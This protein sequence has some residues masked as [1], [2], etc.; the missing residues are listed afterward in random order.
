MSPLLWSIVIF[1]GSLVL[2][3]TGI[4][5]MSAVSV[6]TVLAYV[7][8]GCLDTGK[9]LSGFADP[10]AMI[11]ASMYVL[12]AGFQRTRFMNTLSDWVVKVSKGSMKWAWLGYLLMAALLTSFVPSPISAFLVI[13]PLCIRTCRSF[14]EDPRKYLFP[15]AAVSI[16]CCFTLPFGSA[17]SQSYLS[18][19][20]FEAYGL[21]QYTMIPTDAIRGRWPATVLL[22]VWAYFSGLRA[23]TESAEG[24]DFSRFVPAQQEKP[25]SRLAEWMGPIIFFGT[26][27][28]MALGRYLGIETWQACMAGALAMVIFRVLTEKEAYRALPMSVIFL[29]VGAVATGN[30]LIQTGAG[31]L[32]GDFLAGLLGNTTNNYLVGALF[33]LIPYLL[34]Q[35]LLNSG[36]TAL[37]RPVL[38][39]VC[40]SLGANPVGPSILM[41]SASVSSFFSP[42]A[43]PV[44]P[45][46]MELGGYR[47]KTLVRRG[48]WI[49]ALLAAVQI[50]YVMT[51]FPAF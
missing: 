32:I 25:L 23:K 22:L 50:I 11:Y 38:L 8:T 10:T 47:T 36:V 4:M 2:Y 35:V 42:M 24:I 39:L 6:L 44:V 16:G 9:A 46:C 21:G 28:L 31:T 49:S 37:F 30:A 12:A 41:L 51:V 17:I 13:S 14:G 29:Y 33:Y 3:A 26:I 48:W 15:L 20:F 45:A 19:S 40:A 5:P 34:T 27:V 7:V 18:N 43:T 1:V